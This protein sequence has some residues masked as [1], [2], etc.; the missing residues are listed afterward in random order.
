MTTKYYAG[1][2]ARK[3]PGEYL[4]FMTEVAKKLDSLDYVLRS[5][6]AD[7]ADTA[8]ANGAS[9]SK[10]E[11]YTPYQNDFPQWVNEAAA[12]QC[13][14]F[15]LDNM[16]P[17]VQKLIKRNMYQILGKNDTPVSFVVCWTPTENPYHK[18][19]G[20]TRYATRFARELGIPV[21][22]LNYEPHK[23]RITNWL[24]L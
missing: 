18:D 12:R 23:E 13:H 7:G 4:T 21:F 11:I 20:G 10:M 17:Y 16:K 15:P 5:G 14:E 9:D 1:I 19:A 24:K 6:G 22:N 8:F 2:G 3:T